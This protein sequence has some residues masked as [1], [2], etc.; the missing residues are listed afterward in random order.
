M[1]KNFTIKYSLKSKTQ[2]KI[3]S[4]I[5]NY[6]THPHY[7]LIN[8]IKIYNNLNKNNSTII[9]P[10]KNS[11]NSN[12]NSNANANNS[13]IVTP[14]Q[15]SGKIN[16]NKLIDQFGT[17]PIT[18]DL[19]TQ[20]EKA[21]N[22]PAHPWLK[23]G[24]FFTHRGL[25]SFLNSYSK[26]EPVFLYTGR[27]PSS[28]AMH[29]G[30][31]IPF[32]FT[33]WLQETFNCPLV[34]QISD[35]EKSAFKGI[36]FNEVYKLGYENSKDIIACGFDK[37]KTFI[38]SNRN[39][40]LNCKQFELLSTEMQGITS[41]KEIKR[42]FGLTDENN[43][44]MFK[45][46]FYQTAAAYYLSYPFIFNSEPA[47]CLVAHAIDQDPY[48]RLARDISG[49]MKL[50][51]PSNIMSTF[52]PGLS[53]LDGKM[54]STNSTSNSR[55]DSIFLNDSSQTIKEKVLKYS[56]SGGGGDGS[57]EQHRQF[58][59]DINK[60]IAYQYLRYFEMDD[61]KLEYIKKEFTKGNI[62]CYEMKCLLLDKII[63]LIEEFK[64]NREKISDEIV[65]EFYSWEDEKWK[66]VRNNKNIIENKVDININES[67]VYDYLRKIDIKD[68]ITRYHSDI[69][70]MDTDSLDQLKLSLRGEMCKVT[71]LKAKGRDYY[72]YLSS[73]DKTVDVKDIKKRINQICENKNHNK[74]SKLSFA[75]NDTV[76]YLF[77][78]N[79][80]NEASSIFSIF[81]LINYS[82]Y[83]HTKS[84]CNQNKLTLVIDK[85]LEYNEYVNFTPLTNYASV[86]LSYKNSIKFIES[87]GHIMLFI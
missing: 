52:I 15:V 46:P 51:K 9:D 25:T 41:I 71:L 8:T 43:F 58:G 62:S 27:G 30:H 33:K 66:C 7:S 59:G 80:K 48:F 19:I 23:R 5:T 26:G 84:E 69:K 82:E 39:Y 17:E 14:W 78:R 44:A 47:N 63:P 49:K 60:D 68:F 65:E 53:G 83:N 21:T 11:S 75:G 12:S 54:S 74:I 73:K 55:N 77:N 6:N 64:E 28:Q 42:I 79:N 67:R 72:L 76:E 29:L 34:I 45:W 20:F 35:D 70:F 3:L 38:F 1:L 31:L 18:P 4:K 32:I 22:T 24:I 13:Q 36:P 81:G 16:Y 87:F 50:P 56:Y 61:G 86:S 40:R 10:N 37:S 85:E 2:T 57:L